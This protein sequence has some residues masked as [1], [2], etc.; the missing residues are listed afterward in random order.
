MTGPDTALYLRLF[1]A[2]VP[3]DFYLQPDFW[4]GEKS[5]NP[6]GRMSDVRATALVSVGFPAFLTAMKAGHF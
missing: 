1:T 6:L 3:A 5:D 2:H 4:V